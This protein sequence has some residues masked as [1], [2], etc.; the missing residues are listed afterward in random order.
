[1]KTIDINWL[2][3][4]IFYNPLTGEFFWKSRDR[5]EFTSDR[6][7][8]SWNSTY[9]GKKCGSLTNKYLTIRIK[10][11]LFYCHR[12]AWAIHFGE[13]PENDI[14]HINM[15]KTDNRI[16][17]LRMTSRGQNM[18]N[19][20]ATRANTSGFIGVYWAK[21][22]CKWV[23]GITINYKFQHLGYFDDPIKAAHAYNE[24]CINANGEY[25]K[26]K[27]EYNLA[28]IKLLGTVA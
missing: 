9:S 16:S 10:N 4:I 20:A 11:S 28:Q 15:D 21:R 18:S 6:I 13:W 26:E 2:K 5:K 22:E 24:A 23:A 27:I 7:F 14:D 1:M 25:C 3:S 17:N 19:M 8:K 12:L